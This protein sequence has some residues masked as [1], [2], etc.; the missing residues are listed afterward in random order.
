MGG[1]KDVDWK[2]GEEVWGEGGR[3]RGESF[4]ERI[5]LGGVV[6][7]REKERLGERLGRGIG[8][9]GGGNERVGWEGFL[10]LMVCM[11]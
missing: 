6:G 2:G 5:G 8:V 7:G 9:G 1:G 4:V 11:Y 10:V 3:W